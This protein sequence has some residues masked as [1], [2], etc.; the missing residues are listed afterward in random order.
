MPLG[1]HYFVN[2]LIVVINKYIVTGA[3]NV[4]VYVCTLKRPL[5]ICWSMGNKGFR[6]LVAIIGSKFSVR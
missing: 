5:L 1:S 3:K 4:S 6:I 2:E